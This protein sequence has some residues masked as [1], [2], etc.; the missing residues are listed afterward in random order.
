MSNYTS[1]VPDTAVRRLDWMASMACRVEDP[2]LFSETKHEHEA[3][4]ICAVR[5]PVRTRCLANVKRLERGEAEIRRDG[6]VAGLTARERWRLDAEAPGH[7][8]EKPV[9]VFTDEPP[10]CGTYL[11]LLRHLWLGER[12]DPKCWSAQV[13][14]ERLTRTT[15]AV[16]DGDVAPPPPGGASAVQPEARASAKRKKPGPRCSSPHERRIYTLWVSGASDLDIARRMAISVPAV[17]RVRNR[18]ALLPNQPLRAAS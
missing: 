2:D 4:V 8:K 6:V 13:R 1:S 16:K 12:M 3:R 17:R 14:R 15:A 18:L 9:L 5:C 11:A 10:A 7:S